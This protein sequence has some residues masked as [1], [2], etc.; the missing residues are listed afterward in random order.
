[1]SRFVVT[2]NVSVDAAVEDFWPEDEPDADRQALSGDAKR[3]RLADSP[4]YAD[5]G[6]TFVVCHIAG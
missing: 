1:M 3:P 4:R 5:G 6:I 2:E